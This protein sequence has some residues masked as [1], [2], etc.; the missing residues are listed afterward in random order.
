[1]NSG[2]VYKRQSVELGFGMWGDSGQGEGN[3]AG[4]RSKASKETA[5]RAGNCW[6][7]EVSHLINIEFWVKQTSSPFDNIQA[8]VEH[9][10]T[11]QLN[12]NCILLESLTNRMQRLGNKWSKA[13]FWHLSDWNYQNC[14][15]QIRNLTGAN[16]WFGTNKFFLN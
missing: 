15:S 16:W 3:Y 10:A 13:S 7:S 4:C 8:I 14:M 11:E 6:F 2:I 5:F 9:F 12:S 1:M